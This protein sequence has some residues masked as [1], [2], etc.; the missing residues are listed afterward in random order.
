MLEPS[1]HAFHTA[2]WALTVVA[3][4]A[5]SACS[6]IRHPA[7]ERPA[8]THPVQIDH[9]QTNNFYTS[10]AQ[11]NLPWTTAPVIYASWWKGFN[12]PVLNDLLEEATKNNQSI[13]LAAARITQARAALRL[14]QSS[15]YPSIDLALGVKRRG[16]SENAPNISTGSSNLSTDLQL[17][18]NASYEIDFWG[19][20]AQADAAAQARLLSEQAD[21]ATVRTTLY[22]HV[23]QGYFSLRALDAQRELTYK[24]L[25]TR[26]K[27][28]QLQQL[29][30][31]AGVIGQLDLQQSK[32]EL[33]S[34]Q[35]LHQQTLQNQ[36]NTLIMLATLLGRQ[37]EDILNV[38]LDQRGLTIDK[39]AIQPT[40]PAQLPSDIVSIRPDLIR[41]E[42]ALI[43][44]NADI[45]VARAAYFP[46]LSLT[47]EIGQQSKKLS[48][49]LDPTSLF[50]NLAANL[51]QPIFR[52]GAIDAYVAAANARQEQALAQ[53][54]L[55]V[56]NAFKDTGSALNNL[57]ASNA[58]A[59]TIA[60]RITNL[61]EALR[62]ATL[63]YDNGYSS[64]LEVL[65]AQRE[66]LQAQIGWID[67][68]RNQLNA[69][70]SLYQA[71]GGGWD[72]KAIGVD[73]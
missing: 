24:T 32:A 73:N 70:I 38:T 28:V 67:A 5:L 62:L 21:L 40:V 43:A 66:V 51:T 17:G 4:A 57:Q 26:Q 18:F 64:Y 20:Y 61:Q 56:Q 14:N 23:A 12:D 25:I 6:G 63:R 37:P 46:R 13:A 35:V 54:I 1:K 27:Y 9:Q 53:Y 22:A 11:V 15:L 36:R 16:N 41:A 7:Y 55:A 33:A 31:D 52:G 2:R 45:G 10:D 34:V 8:I 65:N 44:A 69:T 59:N 68:Q 3:A 19:R 71:V 29:R 47:A 60:E 39:L 48:D 72:A 58:V 49:L 50:W 42:Q 30:H